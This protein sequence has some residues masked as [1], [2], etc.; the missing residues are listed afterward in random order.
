MFSALPTK[1]LEVFAFRGGFR[2]KQVEELG[3][4]AI[5]KK[6]TGDSFIG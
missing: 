2:C 6:L 1:F 5:M 4:Y 3:G